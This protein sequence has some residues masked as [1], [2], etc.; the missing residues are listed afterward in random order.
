MTQVDNCFD[1]YADGTVNAHLRPVRI[2]GTFHARR[3]RDAAAGRGDRSAHVL[4]DEVES[5]GAPAVV[6]MMFED[7]VWMLATPEDLEP[8]AGRLDRSSGRAQEVGLEGGGV[9][10]SS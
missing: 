10:P 8:S 2:L 1:G 4:L 3:T 9:D 6:E 7:G 5:S